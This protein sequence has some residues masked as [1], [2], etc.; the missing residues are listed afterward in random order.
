MPGQSTQEEIG[1]LAPATNACRYGA[2]VDARSLFE[3]V[4]QAA[5]GAPKA[6]LEVH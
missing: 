1:S 2:S 5:K 6:A 3:T 4:G